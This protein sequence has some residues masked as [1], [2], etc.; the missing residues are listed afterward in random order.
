MLESP[1]EEYEGPTNIAWPSLMSNSFSFLF[2]F[3]FFFYYYFSF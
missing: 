3:S 2:F 1:K